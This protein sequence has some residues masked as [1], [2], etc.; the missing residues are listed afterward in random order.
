MTSAIFSEVD[1][2]QAGKYTPRQPAI[3]G[4]RRNLQRSYLKR[5]STIVLDRVDV[6]D[7][8][9]AVA[10]AELASMRT[11][12]VAL[13]AGNVELGGYSKAPLQDTTNRIEKIL[14]ARFTRKT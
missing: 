10:S 4:L 2:I 5:L 6:P 1:T 3:S 9:A 12:I 8:A 14:D 11:R 7:D 13:L